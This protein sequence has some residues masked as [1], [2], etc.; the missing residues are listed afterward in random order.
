[1]IQH[2]CD[3]IHVLGYHL[4]VVMRTI[5]IDMRE[6][7]GDSAIPHDRNQR[8]GRL[9]PI[10]DVVRAIRD[11]AMVVLVD[12]EDRENEGDLIIA[13]EKIT[14][15]SVNFMITHGKGLLCMPMSA[16]RAAEL[17]L[18]PMVARN[19]DDFGTAF[20]ISCDATASHGVTTGISASDRAITISLGA[21]GGSADDFHRPGHVFPLIARDGGT[22]TRVGHT[23]AGVDLARM[24]G[25][26]PVAAII[27]IVGE[28]GEM[29]RFPDLIEWCAEHG[30]LMTTIEC[31]REYRRKQIDAGVSIDRNLDGVTF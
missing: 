18:P 20:T 5:G 2:A 21:K 11:G 17:D 28:D 29:L 14:S 3:N 27:E 13:A 10:E 1:M 24:A 16:E 22:L 12:D 8:K 25:L 26:E 19:E 4:D 15:E 31:L 6:K 30:L 9:A 23:E 7:Q